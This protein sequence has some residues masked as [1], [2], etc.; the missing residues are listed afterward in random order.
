MWNASC[1]VPY[2]RERKS[3]GITQLFLLSARRIQA[4][5]V[6]CARLLEVEGN[7]HSLHIHL[8]GGYTLTVSR[9][10]FFE[11]RGEIP[12]TMRDHR[13]N[14]T[15]LLICLSTKKHHSYLKKQA[16][17]SK[18]VRREPAWIPVLMSTFGCHH[19]FFDSLFCPLWPIFWLLAF[20]LACELCLPPPSLFSFF[21]SLSLP[22]PFC[23]FSIFP[24]Y[25]LL[26][27]SFAPSLLPS[28]F[29]LLPSHPLHAYIDIPSKSKL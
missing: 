24:F 20:L 3:P 4:S 7:Q 12:V 19:L 25:L 22:L 10:D 11:Q 17:T 8:R 2:Q 21:L 27:R 5:R 28:F 15:A 23:S 16:R 14:L 13:I 18:G 9:L 26:L 1:W 6:H 29:F